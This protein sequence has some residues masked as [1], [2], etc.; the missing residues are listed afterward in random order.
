MDERAFELYRLSVVESMPDSDVKI[1]L[2]RAI[3]HKLR[4]LDGG[5]GAEQPATLADRNLF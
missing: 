2:I 4:I 5:S 3:E 1:A